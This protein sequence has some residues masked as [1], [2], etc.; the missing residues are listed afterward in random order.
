MRPVAV[1]AMVFPVIVCGCAGGPVKPGFYYAKPGLTETAY[2]VDVKLCGE[3]GR[4]AMRDY[5]KQPQPVAGATP[6]NY[7]D[8]KYGAGPGIAA[9][10]T[11]SFAAGYQRG[12]A[13]AQAYAQA[14][15]ACMLEKGYGEVPL[16]QAEGEAF[17]SL[18]RDERNQQFVRWA[19]GQ[20]RTA[21][22]H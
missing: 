7:H 5:G 10:A 19:T 15:K 13:K 4:Q 17:A 21:N 6:I 11:Y 9:N 18:S 2:Q 1:L 16:T 20:E 8:K 3:R 22:S 12:Q 14:H